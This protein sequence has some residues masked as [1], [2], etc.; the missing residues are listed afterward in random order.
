MPGT[1]AERSGA[2]GLELAGAALLVFWPVLLGTYVADD[3]RLL[4][5]NP[6]VQAGDF[7][8]LLVRPMFGTEGG[9]W[10]PLT[11]LALAALRNDRFGSALAQ[12]SDPRASD[13]LMLMGRDAESMATAF[14]TVL[15]GY[16]ENG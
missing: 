9:Y 7:G 14:E 15:S 11:M 2:S 8:A 10:R 1:H 12:I 16:L 6:A 3:L 5:H 13:A 4:A